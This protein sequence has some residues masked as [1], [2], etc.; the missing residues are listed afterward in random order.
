MKK[1]HTDLNDLHERYGLSMLENTGRRNIL[2]S[3]VQEE[4]FAEALSSSYEDVTNNGRTGEPDIFVGEL[5]KELECKITTP[6]PK[7]GINLQTDYRTLQKK[8]NLDFLYVIADRAFEKF[9][10]LH[11][12]DLNANDF[13]TP[14][15]S[16]RG[17]AKLTKH[18]A[19]S[20]CNVLWGKVHSKN[21]I[22]L[23]KL[24]KK[25]KVCS[26]VAVKKKEK[27]VK[28]MNYWQTQPTNYKYEF[29]EVA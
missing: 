8:G 22:E 24:Q 20:K 25:L 17:K 16:S 3:S 1:F 19:A 12:N 18:I 15:A 21:D 27:I 5:N 26:E 2:M 7:G 29:E 6:S 10:V 13:T 23:A 28:S 11:Y 14:S 9:V 4:F